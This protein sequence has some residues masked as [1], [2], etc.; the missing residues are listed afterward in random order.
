MNEKKGLFVSGDKQ[1]LKLKQREIKREIR[2]CKEHYKVKIQKCFSSGN[3]KDTWKGLK[4][5]INY[6]PKP[7]SVPDSIESN[8]LNRFY[9]RFDHTLS[10]LSIERE[11]CRIERAA[12]DDTSIEVSEEETQFIFSKVNERKAPG[13][14]G[15]KGKILKECS[16]QLSYIFTYIFNMSIQ[17]TS[18]PCIWKTSKIIPVPKKDKIDSKN[19]LRPVALTSIVM[20]SFER[21][22]LYKIRDQFGPHAD[23]HQF[24]YRPNRSVEDAILLFTNNIYKHLDHPGRYCRLLFADF[25][26]A[27]NTMQP[28]LLVQKMSGLDMNNHII[29]WVLEFLTNRVQYVQIG[30]DVSLNMTTNI[31]AP[32]GCVLSPVLFTIY[33]NDCRSQDPNVPLIKFADDT[34]LQ[35][36]ITNGNEEGYRAE[37]DRFVSWCDN[38][39][40]ELNI[41]KTRELVIDFRKVKEPI[42]PLRLK[43]QIVD[44][45]PH[46]KYLGVTIDERLQWSEH[47]KTMKQK[48]SKRMYF[49]TK[50]RQFRIDRTLC[51]MFYRA[52]IESVII[53]CIAAWGGNCL[54]VNKNEMNRVIRKAAKSTGD[55]G[56]FDELLEKSTF[57]KI[58]AIIDD[59]SHPLYP[60]ITISERSGR[61]ISIRTKTERH[62]MSF[63]PT[64]I[65]VFNTF[66]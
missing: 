25:S 13:P 9:C 10:S 54:A 19:D 1:G 11:K 6:T 53:F 7:T 44:Q 3:M 22:I 32:Q 12:E 18:I 26:S 47:V 49:L 20:K 40:L 61:L 52:V 50:L 45:V 24:A 58:S 51:T 16:E 36:L 4:T 41:S 48:L 34:T 30:N 66:R 46:Y 14:D 27:F 62:R 59:K 57:R 64:G 17:C 37:I 60:S 5:A 21:L 42:E 31:G 65:R 29:A 43:N 23:S 33:T 63:L 55:I 38:H 28:E 39:H 35:G 2:K 15:I 8:D 56:D